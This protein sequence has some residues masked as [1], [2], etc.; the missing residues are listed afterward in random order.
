MKI[1]VLLKEVPD[2]YGERELDLETG[3]ADRGATDAV[4]DEIGERALEVALSHADHHAGATV[5]I[6]SM[7]PGT[8]TANLRKALAMGATSAIH[9]V[10][11][12]LLGA[13][14]SLTTE[15]LAATIKHGQF[16]LVIGGNLSTD[17]SAGVLPS[18]LAELLGLPHL[19]SLRSVSINESGV[20]GQRATESGVATVEASLPAVIS[21]TE[22]LP[23][24]RFPN[25]KGI[26]A[27]KKK[28]LKTITLADIDVDLDGESAGRSILIA[29]AKR[30][31]R[32]AGM[33]I[34]DEGDAAERLAE[35]LVTNR[36]A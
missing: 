26:I 14:L 5:T 21:V 15:V 20:S 24:A 3:L 35:F 8:A 27:A 1:A 13:D 9:V 25:F 36:L 16:D 30:P 32:Q 4:L 17:G 18:M 23:A 29:V 10:D 11:D 34:I 28:E 33:K 19:T 6:V 22:A 7:G 12:R 31:A 2:T